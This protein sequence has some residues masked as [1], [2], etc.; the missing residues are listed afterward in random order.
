MLYILYK[1]LYFSLSCGKTDAFLCVGLSKYL[2]VFVPNSS[3]QTQQ[4][5]VQ[6]EILHASDGKSVS[7]VHRAH[8]R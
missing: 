5:G 2:S 8:K 7:A 3:H 1:Q 6:V 4:A